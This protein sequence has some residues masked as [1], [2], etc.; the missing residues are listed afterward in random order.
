MAACD[1]G[2]IRSCASGAMFLATFG[3]CLRSRNTSTAGCFQR[4]EIYVKH[5]PY[6]AATKGEGELLRMLAKF[7]IQVQNW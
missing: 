1:S 6:Y 3:C 5:E 4:L 7:I 2:K